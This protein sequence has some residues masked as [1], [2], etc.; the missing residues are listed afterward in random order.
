M[1]LKQSSL[2]RHHLMLKPLT[3]CK[4][5]FGPFNIFQLNAYLQYFKRSEKS[6]SSEQ[7]DGN[8]DIYLFENHIKIHPAVQ[9]NALVNKLSK[10]IQDIKGKGTKVL[11]VYGLPGVGKKEL[12]RQF[13]K[14]H[15][16][17]LE[18]KE[19]PK[20]FVA[21]INASD[22]NSFHQDLF[23]IAEQADAIENFQ[24]YT[25][26]T[27]KPE[28][29][30]YILGKI[31]SRLKDRKDWLLVLKDINLSEELKWQ[32]GYTLPENM[33][34]KKIQAINL[35]DYLPSPGD[36]N[37]G[38]IILT[39]SNDDA[40]LHDKTHTK[41]VTISKEMEDEEALELLQYA[42]GFNNLHN[43]K[44]A[45]QVVHGLENVPTSVFW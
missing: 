26:M 19:A 18:K 45:L 33:E 35:C 40:H 9:R 3:V 12:V 5:S 36:P 14:Q 28:G 22:P 32:I 13:A 11:Y 30:Q 34:F 10:S 21:M 24:E 16:E 41:C 17:K 37:H 4:F 25:S 6:E 31:S 8:R 15:Y 1:Y 39:T 20:K 38:T 44:P 2:F 42:S 27:S 7:R 23:K 29:Y 43:C